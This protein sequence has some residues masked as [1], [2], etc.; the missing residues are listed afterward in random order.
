MSTLTLKIERPAYGG[1]YIGRH[2]GKVV[3]IKGAVLP[4][5]TVEAIIEDEKKDY[6][7]A[8]V[9]K[10]LESSPH[11]I[12]PACRYF[13]VCGGCHLQ[14]APYA[15]QV[16]L[17]QE[18]L[19]DCLKRLA[20][21]ENDLGKPIID[22][23]PWNYRLRG[24]FK[25]SH[26]VIGLYRENTREVVDMDNCPLMDE[27]INEG[28]KN[29]KPLLKSFGIREIHITTGDRSTA[30]IKLSSSGKSPEGMNELASLFQQAGFSGLY[31]ET[32]DKKIVRYGEPYVTLSLQDLKYTISPMAFFQS[33][34]RLNQTVVELIKN[35][36]KP[37]K[38]IKVLDLYSG[39]GNFSIPL[40]ADADVIAVE[41]NPYAIEDGRRNLKSNGIRNY[42][43]INS[44][45]E[46]FHFE[47]RFDI[48]ILDPPRTGV[49]NR[50]AGKILDLMPGRIVYIS[51]NPATF[52]RDLKKLQRK[53]E[54]E[55]VG[56][57]DFFP[58]T[59]HVESLAIFRL[60]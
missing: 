26:G 42:R 47:G 32:R 18:I 45:A 51:C 44:S 43:L 16:R 35:S 31:I 27:K 29:I 50:V 15:L 25:T 21:I 49:T 56:I 4:G 2:E 57:I 3:M 17:K 1:V 30:L 34:W 53:Y 6:I 38:G 54:I 23:D 59:Y 39:A 58:Q 9:K 14:H 48:V 46:D 41:E 12:R 7:A 11:R 37:L 36:L 28:L 60:R 33:H 24:Q 52:A 19:R 5:E 13:G 55:S 10:I 8:S 40:A 22:A 20:Q